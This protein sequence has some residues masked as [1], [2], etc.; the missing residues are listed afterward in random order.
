MCDK[1]LHINGGRL[2]L[3]SNMKK[4]TMSALNYLRDYILPL[5]DHENREEVTQF[6]QLCAHLCIPTYGKNDVNCE[7]QTEGNT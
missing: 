4:D 2:E 5:V 6:K 3:N 1:K 7:M